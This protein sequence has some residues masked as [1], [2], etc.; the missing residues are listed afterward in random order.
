MELRY[1]H[2]QT[3]TL[4]KNGLICRLETYIGNNVDWKHK[5]RLETLKL[6]WKH[7]KY[8]ENFVLRLE[9]KNVRLAERNNA[10]FFNS[11][12]KI[13]WTAFWKLFSYCGPTLFFR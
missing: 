10:S 4:S 9:T 2:D 8:I 7:K 3:V 6:D 13:K 5:N 12:W 1:L 11:Q